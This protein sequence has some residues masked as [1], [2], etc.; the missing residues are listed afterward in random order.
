MFVCV[1]V[2]VCVCVWVG[3]WVCW[4]LSLSCFGLVWFG[5]S[6]P[7][8]RSMLDFPKQRLGS[9]LAYFWL[10]HGYL[11]ASKTNDLRAFVYK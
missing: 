2:C 9:T 6:E 1:C 4:F 10:N 7:G 8:K 5:Y 3:G 11:C